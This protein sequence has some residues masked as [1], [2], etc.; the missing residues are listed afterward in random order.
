MQPTVY[1]ERLLLTRVEKIDVGFLFFCLSSPEA[2]GAFLSAAVVEPEVVEKRLL[3]GA[4][5]NDDSKTFIVKLKKDL[6]R[7]GMFHFW[8]KPDDRSTAMYTIQIAVMEHRNFG[9]GTEVQLAAVDALFHQTSLENVEVYTDMNNI[10]EVRCL[11]K[12]GFKYCDSKTYRDMDVER[13][14][15]LYRLTREE[16]LQMRSLL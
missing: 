3:S 4:Y 14:G 9:Y 2:H 13:T 7:I 11:E 10:A 15:N 12:L 5:W 8:V 6:T 1:T 16:Y